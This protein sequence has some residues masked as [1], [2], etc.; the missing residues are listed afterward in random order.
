MPKGVLNPV[1]EQCREVTRELGDETKAGIARVLADRKAIIAAGH[2]FDVA[3]L[4]WRAFK[5]ELEAS[6]YAS[7]S[8]RAMLRDGRIAKYMQSVIDNLPPVYM[9]ETHDK[10]VVEHAAVLRAAKFVYR[11]GRMS[12]EQVEAL[13]LKHEQAS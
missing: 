5:A 13:G 10:Y 3:V 6:G 9:A 11:G 2:D 8:L 12:R 7:P 4:A 1:Y